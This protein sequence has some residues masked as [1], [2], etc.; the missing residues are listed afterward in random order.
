MPIE[1]KSQGINTN[2]QN[3]PGSRARNAR[4]AHH[5]TPSL[6]GITLQ[7]GS[8]LEKQE[9]MSVMEACAHLAGEPHSQEPRAVSPVL[10]DLVSHW[11]DTLE[12]PS[13]DRIILPLIPSIIR[14]G[15]QR[16]TE[17]ATRL[18]VA[19]WLLH[20][21]IPIWAQAADLPQI[22][23]SIAQLP[24][25]GDTPG[26]TTLAQLDHHVTKLTAT[27]MAHRATTPDIFTATQPP[28]GQDEQRDTQIR[29]ALWF[30]GW[31]SATLAI[32]PL[33]TAALHPS[34]TR[35][36]LVHEAALRIINQ[37]AP[38]QDPLAMLR[39]TVQATQKSLARAILA[40]AHQ[41]AHHAQ[42]QDHPA[43]LS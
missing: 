20:T 6:R 29:Q 36:G 17:R 35:K 43:Q 27:A 4:P 13:R 22:A 8:H 31:T 12:Q 40:I 37:A 3:T 32:L 30:S 34:T 14:T 39:P 16:G 2:H 5:P 1:A 23:R 41:G 25:V 26:D 10:N 33:N 18:L 9:G 28:P 42:T 15:P 38:A 11:S 21:A 7:T 19:D 24:P